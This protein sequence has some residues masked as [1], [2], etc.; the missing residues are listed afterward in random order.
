MLQ[1]PWKR[2]SEQKL[3]PLAKGTSTVFASVRAR[4]KRPRTRRPRSQA[5]LGVA[6]LLAGAAPTKQKRQ[7]RGHKAAPQTPPPPTAA[8]GR[9]SGPTRLREPTA[10]GAARRGLHKTQISS[11]TRLGCPTTHGDRIKTPREPFSSD[12]RTPKICG[13]DP[14]RRTSNKPLVPREQGEEA[15][16]DEWGII[17]PDR[18]GRLSC[19]RTKSETSQERPRKRCKESK[20]GP[21]GRDA[22]RNKAIKVLRRGRGRAIAETDHQGPTAKNF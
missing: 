16:A 4:A 9:A 13:R 22:L 10:R 14:L 5:S 2:N 7:A 20:G 18:D 6:G 21:E 8:D 1:W 17:A 15:A 3:P 12:T 19:G 11:P